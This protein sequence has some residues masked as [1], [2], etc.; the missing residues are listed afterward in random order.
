[1]KDDY[2][3]QAQLER[4]LTSALHRRTVSN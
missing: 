3:K 1:M 2:N 4:F